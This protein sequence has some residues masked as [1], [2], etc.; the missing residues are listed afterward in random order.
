M[1]HSFQTENT[2]QRIALDISGLKIDCEFRWEYKWTIFNG[3]GSGKAVLDQS[4]SAS[5][6]LDFASEDY[7]SYPP[8]D[9]SI[10]NCNSNIQIGDM[11]FDGDGLGIIGGIISLFEGLLRDT[12]E[13]ELE[14]TVCSELRGLG[15]G[16]LTNLLLSLSDQIDVYLQPLSINDQDHL[17]LESN[18][19]IPKSD[20]DD[21]PLYLN[22][23][24][25]D[26]YAGDWVNTI[27]DKLDTFIGGSSDSGGELGINSFIRDNL[28]DNKGQLVLDPSFLFDTGVMFE[29]HDALTESILSINSIAIQGL[30]MFQELDLLNAIGN[31]TLQNSLKLDSLTIVM[32]LKAVMKASSK[33][34]ALIAA[35][36]SPPIEETF[37][38]DFTLNG[39]DIDFSVLL[40]L[41]TE[42]LGSLQ[43]GSFLHTD[44]II[45]CILSAAE[46]VKFTELSVSVSD[47]VPPTLN[48]FLDGGID[49]VISTGAVALFHMYEQV[50]IRAM[51]NFFQ[52]FV[53]DMVNDYIEDALNLFE[54][55]PTNDV[56]TDGYIDFRDLFLA[57][58]E[59]ANAGGSGDSPYGNVIPWV[60][61]IVDDQLFSANDAG[62]LAINDVI[63]RPLTKSQSGTE[64]SM[65]LKGTLLDL[66]KEE[67]DMDLWKAFADNLRL[68]L[69]NL[70]VSGLDT[71]RKPIKVLQP[72]SSFGHVLENQV[73]LG[74]NTTPLDASVEFE[75]VI[76]DTK[77]PLATSNV[78]DLR[79]SI[80]SL[81]L[82][83]DIFATVQESKFM[84]L[85]LKDALNVDCWLSMIPRSNNIS[86][87]VAERASRF[88]RGMLLHFFDM[89]F[90][91]GM[92]A[93][94]S[95]ISCSND[96]LNN[97]NDVLK[98][99]EENEFMNNLQTRASSISSDLLEGEWVQGMIDSRLDA[100]SRRCPH[101][102]NYG[103]IA[104]E[105]SASPFKATY[106]LVDG[107][108]YGGMTLV[109]LIA[110]VMAQKHTNITSSQP[111]TELDLPTVNSNLVDFT[112]LT[113]IASWADT[114]L[115]EARSY[116][117]GIVE[118]EDGSQVP[119]VVDMLRS[120][121]LD[122]GGL[123]TIPIVDKGFEAGGV[124]LSLYN[125]TLIGLDSFSEFNVLNAK[126]P[127]EFSNKVKLSTL[128]VTLDMGLSVEDDRA[129]NAGE[130][131]TI[132]VS[133]VF[134]DVELDV[135]FL[136]A[137]DQDLLG[138]L[139]LGS[140]MNTDDIFFCVISA[141]HDVGLSEF[142]MSIGDVSEFSISGFIMEA[143][144]EGIKNFTDSVFKE[145]KPMIVDTMPAFTSKTVRPLLDNVFRVLM[146]MGKEGTCP[147]PKSLTG[148][149]DFRDL[150]LPMTKAAELLGKG[151]SQYGDFFRLLHGFI[152]D[153]A[154]AID[155]NGMS[156]LNE[157]FLTKVTDNG[158]LR[159]PGV[160]F[161]QDVSIALNGLNADISI[162][163][164]DVQV[165]NMDTLG[166][167]V[168]LLD[169]INGESSVL[170]NSAIIGVGPEA[171]R[172][173]LTLFINA[174]GDDLQ[175][176]NELELGLTLSSANMI[177]ELLAEIEEV[178]LLQFP[179]KDAMNVNCWLATVVTPVLDKYGVRAGDATLGLR[180][181]ALAVAE[182]RL[183]M[184]C[185][186][187]SSPALLDMAEF[188]ASEEGVADT[189]SVANMM[190]EYGSNLLQGGFVQNR[191]D[192]MLN[193][194][195]RKCPHSTAYNQN[196]NGLSYEDM[197]AVE[198]QV[199]SYGFLIAIL[200]VV[201]CIVLLASFA[202]VATR[203]IMRRR[204]N[205][206][207]KQLS[208]PQILLLEKEQRSEVERERDLNSRMHS[209]VLSKDVPLVMRICI[210]F[211]ILG[212]VALFLSGHLSLGGTV[213]ISGAF[214]GEE[215]NIEGFFE[216]SMAKSTLE[217]WNA[218]AKAL[219]V[220][221]VL[222]SGIWP[223]AKQFAALF[224]WLASPSWVSSKRRGSILHGLDVLG[225][226][227]FVDIFVLLLTLASF[228]ISIE[229]PDLKFLPKELYSINML[230]RPLWG[231]YA[232]SELMCF[233]LY[234][235]WNYCV[236]ILSTNRSFFLLVLAQ[237]LSQVSSHV[238]IH[239]HRK[240][241][242]ANTRSQDWSITTLS[243]ES[244]N[245]RESLRAH[246][247]KLD[248]EA[249]TEHAVVRKWVS[250]ALL[251]ALVAFT[252]LVMLGCSLPSFD[253]DILGLLGIAVESSNG[254]EQASYS[255]SVFGLANMIMDEARYLGT[256]SDMIG[257]GALASILVVTVFI[258]PLAQTALLLVEWFVPITT[259]Q[260]KWNFALL[261]ALSA[262]Q[263]MEVYVLS[264]VIAAW[265][266]GGVSSFM[267]N[268]YCGM[269]DGFFTTLAF[270][271]IVDESDAQCFR[272]EASV[273]TA[274]WMLFA[275]SILLGL[276]NHFIL[277][278]SKQKHKDECIHARRLHSDRWQPSKLDVGISETVSVS[279]DEEEDLNNWRNNA[280]APVAPRFTDFYHFA[281]VRGESRT[282]VN[283][284][285]V[286]S[287]VTD[288]I[289]SATTFWK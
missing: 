97:F 243:S 270:Y 49:H 52:T 132:T 237:I 147:D 68:R 259:K 194:A 172:A 183:D 69:S 260:R 151:V 213:N 135:S 139:K 216:F 184:N 215:F 111:V 140:I 55:C 107:I 80:P 44:N 254:F 201:V 144:E 16:A 3:S 85:P 154:S 22:F 269:L 76:G 167:P 169:P 48:G 98:F 127:H 230:V 284:G 105:L 228:R 277:Q 180:K 268:E 81:E 168:T 14:S 40:G 34:D 229:S 36:N 133:L 56:A 90:P 226:W 18:I 137:M 100:A 87:E 214:A 196:F 67:V 231:L 244:Q 108:M 115:D 13:G 225:K 249:S 165:S 70:R 232:N 75:L 266:L 176:S 238:I 66:N 62:L 59:S 121:A 189:T 37:T 263:Y 77:S 248:Y 33:A 236:N 125:V 159:F 258:V 257:L 29:S 78:M 219:A 74:T 187:C 220:L 146:G 102:P 218:G 88:D 212:N 131:E 93:E 72:N 142:T 104:S 156:K 96:M 114:V 163:I 63:V 173:S 101:D 54:E 7:S 39:I 282:D 275:G 58:D 161:S 117:S 267:I 190:F 8:N 171:L 256:V 50:L 143:T 186:S 1:N 116:L 285:F 83:A 234:C 112:N 280:V 91:G 64:G 210:P 181:M 152:T 120:F 192:R 99:L 5:V 118:A 239:Y 250:S 4:S 43:M 223:Y 177:L 182:A 109:Q 174:E 20:D 271:G 262:W 170:N 217:M 160:L 129:P 119:G 204:H 240:T 71:F 278:A 113:S 155:K 179:L 45:P 11:D 15:D 222:F 205:N 134:E 197:E 288:E 241:I 202:A 60:I 6:A 9:V 148:L 193:E 265:Q 10:Q 79:L 65:K 138:N 209:L 124:A 84:S 57:P 24:E 122:D 153:G 158:D 126:G 157:M 21:L 136:M 38:V 150:F 123:L 178:S 89:V 17:L 233:V 255:Y 46:R 95:C 149:V 195:S 242:E 35:P 92:A 106:E 94:T 207:V 141:I 224:L 53:R 200:T 103:D 251:V 279:M 162:A 145:Y 185:I 203:L 188:F 247:F 245:A 199:E 175:V 283:T 235:S 61:G 276:V 261:E 264:I 274:S 208:R 2:L 289:E 47:M 166:A 272:V 73:S 19:N 30:D 26:S 128:G 51:P 281:T 287:T 86:A 12:V 227:S 23:L 246:R 42:T 82:F 110:I 198:Q 31:H 164:S 252:L 253:I 25:L 130:M 286:I 27:L 206:W 32:D 273:S 211:I 41:N 191:I 221:I 28:L